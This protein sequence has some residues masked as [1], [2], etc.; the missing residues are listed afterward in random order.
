MAGAGRPTLPSVDRDRPRF[1]CP[2]HFVEPGLNLAPLPFNQKTRKATTATAFGLGATMHSNLSSLPLSPGFSLIRCSRGCSIKTPADG[3]SMHCLLHFHDIQKRYSFSLYR[4]H[5]VPKHGPREL[6][7]TTKEQ[8]NVDFLAADGMTEL[9][10]FGRGLF[11]E[12][13][14]HL[15]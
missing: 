5:N 11:H 3:L 14:S 7:S 12:I 4:M 6:V 1:R 9:H 2:S 8:V 13:V 15:S 10:S